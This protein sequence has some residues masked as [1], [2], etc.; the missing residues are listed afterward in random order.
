MVKVPVR[1]VVIHGCGWLL[2][3]RVTARNASTPSRKRAGTCNAPRISTGN[4]LVFIVTLVTSK[5]VSLK[6]KLLFSNGQYRVRAVMGCWDSFACVRVSPSLAFANVAAYLNNGKHRKERTD[7]PPTRSYHSMH[8]RSSR[9]CG[10]FE[11]G[12]CVNRHDY[13]VL[14]HKTAMRQSTRRSWN[15]CHI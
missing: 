5:S 2:G 7:L 11:D 10:V 9:A 6:T 12:R 8:S 1:I 13:G 3:L 15:R 4:V 14:C